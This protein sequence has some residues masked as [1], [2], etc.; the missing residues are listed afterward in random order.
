LRA[1]AS[2]QTQL[3]ATNPNPHLEKTMKKN[4]LK[5]DVTKLRTLNGKEVKTPVGGVCD[6]SHGGT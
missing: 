3:L 1:A 5:L 2:L 4:Q 6:C